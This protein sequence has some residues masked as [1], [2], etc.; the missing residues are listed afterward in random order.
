MR[1]TFHYDS[2][3]FQKQ[4]GNNM[5]REKTEELTKLYDEATGTWKF[6]RKDTGPL[7]SIETIKHTLARLGL[8]RNEAR[9]YLHLARHEECKA[10]EVSE[11][12]CLH[13]TETYRI[14]RDLEKQGL[15]SSVFEKPLKFVA[16]PFQKAIELL[17]EAKKLRIRFLEQKKESLFDAWLSLPHSHVTTERKKV[18]QI[19][20]GQEQIDLKANE[21]LE[22][23]R[24]K[25]VVFAPE[26]DLSHLYYSGFIDK[27]EECCEKSIDIQLLTNESPKSR[28]F[29]EKTELDIKYSSSN[30]ADLPGFIVVDK[31]QLLLSIVKDPE[32]GHEKRRR[33]TALST[34]YSA[35]IKILDRLFTE[36]WCA[37]ASMEALLT[38]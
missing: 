38:V 35:F 16:T 31:E 37:E 34:N 7:K 6:V 5:V 9:V 22:K 8:S 18:F 19:L 32:E 25:V 11:A 23:A 10:S 21:I 3:T 27:L 12:L 36:L 30:I 14:L 29:N 15:V 13:R 24:H 17:I 28:F 33:L 20:E 4:D 26:A 1:H 2:K